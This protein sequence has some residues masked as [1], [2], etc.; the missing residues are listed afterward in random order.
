MT[1]LGGDG[2]RSDGRNGGNRSG[3]SRI[4]GLKP[5]PCQKYMLFSVLNVKRRAVVVEALGS[6]RYERSPDTS[7]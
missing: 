7:R 4:E 1:L 5:G 6:G 3:I 2:A